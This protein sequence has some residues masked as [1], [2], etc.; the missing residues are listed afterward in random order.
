MPA[1]MIG[2][3]VETMDDAPPTDQIERIE[4]IRC[5]ASALS[6]SGPCWVAGDK[7]DNEAQRY[8]IN[9][10]DPNR[11]A[12]TAAAGHREHE[13]GP[14]HTF[15]VTSNVVKARGLQSQGAMRAAVVYY[16]KPMPSTG[17][18]S[19]LASVLMISLSIKDN[20]QFNARRS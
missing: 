12:L 9:R 18:I 13:Y 5:M 1:E 15:I 14:P 3:N 2:R 10:S 16:Y 7:G 17:R 20:I 19:R 11:T 8:N 6:G 4:V